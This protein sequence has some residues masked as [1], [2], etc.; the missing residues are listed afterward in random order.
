M[1]QRTPS[2]F[3][4]HITS[5]KQLDTNDKLQH[6]VIAHGEPERTRA[7]RPVGVGNLAKVSH[8]DV[9]AEVSCQVTVGIADASGDGD[10]DPMVV[11]GSIIRGAVFVARSFGQIT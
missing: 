9:I 2:V 5:G 3:F 11:V 8:T 1:K 7:P 10:V 4:R 6:E